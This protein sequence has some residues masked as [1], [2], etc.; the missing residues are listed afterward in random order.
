M[1][2]DPSS[3]ST[4][5]A[6]V[7]EEGKVVHSQAIRVPDS[8]AHTRNM[9]TYLTIKRVIE[10]HLPILVAIE[11]PIMGYHRNVRGLISLAKVA[12]VAA[13]TV[14]LCDV[15]HIAVS[16]TEWKSTILGNGRLK[17]EEIAVLSQAIFGL[18]TNLY[19]DEYDAICIAQ[20]ALVK[21]NERILGDG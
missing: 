4:G 19:Q 2:I 10:T 8:R 21:W 13:I 11:D 6:I 1:G 3:K 5:L 15:A 12:G 16:N 18:D 7:D 17:K 20:L 9:E 14:E